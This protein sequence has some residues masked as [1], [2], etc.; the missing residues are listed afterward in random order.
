ME[1]IYM[2]KAF[3]LAEVLITLSIIGIVAALT[4]PTLIQNH[5]KHEASARLKKF[6][7]IISQAIL[8]SE[9]EHNSI[10]NW[11]MTTYLE[12]EDG[13]YDYKANG[14]ITNNFF[15]K[16]IEPY[17][18]YV[19]YEEAKAVFDEDGKQT[20]GEHPTI[21]LADGSTFTIMNSVCMDFRFDINGDRNPNKLGKDRFVFVLCPTQEYRNRF[22]T[23]KNSKFCTYNIDYVNNPSREISLQ[24]CKNSA[25]RCSGLLEIDGWK[26]KDD[27]PYK[28]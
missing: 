26:F 1:D 20:D 13:Q 24:G 17:I 25:Y 9:S 16:Y 3:T 7:S 10:D 22:C 19:K 14:N 18:K 6:Y 4:M 12:T 11:E 21:Y 2:K 15:F 5:K 8:L 27:Y 28:L 23:N